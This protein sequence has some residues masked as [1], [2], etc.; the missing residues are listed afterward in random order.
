MYGA[1][2]LIQSGEVEAWT[3]DAVIGAIGAVAG[4]VAYSA[5]REPA[6]VAR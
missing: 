3:T 5:G 2:T 1:L 6:A 4:V